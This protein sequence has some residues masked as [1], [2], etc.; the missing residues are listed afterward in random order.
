MIRSQAVGMLQAG[1][2]QKFVSLKLG[3]NIR[4]VQRWWR[5]FKNDL[6]LENKGGRGRKSSISKVAKIVITKSIGKNDSLTVY[7]YLTKEK[8]V[9]SYKRQRQPVITEKNMAAR[10][11]FCKERVN[12]TANDWKN[13]LFTDESPFELNHPPN[14]K[15]DCVWARNAL[16]VEPVQMVKFPKKIQVWGMMSHRALSEL[17]FI[18]VGQTVSAEYYVSEI[19]GKTLMSTMNRK[20][21]RGTVVER[22]MLKICPVRYFN[23]M[24]LQLTRQT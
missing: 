6:T 11:K 13:I 15:N 20:R 8:G 4:T 1:S 18:P 7:R 5:L 14:R 19:L 3:V 17:H 16:D 22:K 12:W 24:A 21:E 23:K 2:S 9:K 10:L